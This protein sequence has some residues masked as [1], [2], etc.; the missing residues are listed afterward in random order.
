MVEVVGD[1]NWVV[2]FLEV[3][4]CG[5]VGCCDLNCFWIGVVEICVIVIG[6]IV[7]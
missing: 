2:V 1:L 6:G 4:W 7:G 5:V 3:V